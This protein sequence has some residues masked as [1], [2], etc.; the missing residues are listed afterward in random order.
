MVFRWVERQAS[1]VREVFKRIRCLRGFRPQLVSHFYCKVWLVLAAI[2]RS[3]SV[4]TAPISQWI[5]EY[6]PENLFPPVPFTARHH[7]HWQALQFFALYNHNK[8]QVEIE[9]RHSINEALMRLNS[10]LAAE[11]NF[12]SGDASKSG[13]RII[14]I[15]EFGNS[16]FRPEFQG[17]LIVTPNGCSLRGN[18]AL[19]RRASGPFKS[20]FSAV[21]ALIILSAGVG[22]Q[23]GYAQWWQVP[24]VGA[25]IMMGGIGFLLFAKRYYSSDQEW[26]V[27]KLRTELEAVAPAQR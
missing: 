4:V 12:V 20:W 9:T 27:R 13:V 23:T 1:T 10:F 2:N 19:S 22:L 18:F 17:A 21:C 11:I 3:V 6:P 8:V 5:Q 24:S 14:R 15:Q 16:L 25:C 7:L 26:I